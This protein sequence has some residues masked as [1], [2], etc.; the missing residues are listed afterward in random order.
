MSP[1]NQLAG[2]LCTVSEGVHDSTGEVQQSTRVS[3]PEIAKRLQIGRQAVYGMLER[4]IIPGIRFGH[5]WIV[6]RYAYE[7]WEKTCGAQT[8]LTSVTIG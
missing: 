1:V 3:I 6:T 8:A 5:R 7:R 2:T 4:G